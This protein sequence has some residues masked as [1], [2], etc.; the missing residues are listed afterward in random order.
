MNSIKHLII[1]FSLLFS[2]SIASAE[3]PSS[4]HWTL[5]AYNQ[6]IVV[7]KNNNSALLILSNSQFE[8]HRLDLFCNSMENKSSTSIALIINDRSV[9]F[10]TYCS[11]EHRVFTPK[12]EEGLV[13]IFSILMTGDTMKISNLNFTTNKFQHVADQWQQLNKDAI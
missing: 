5:N 4:M 6:P 11:N 10:I 3:M 13:F 12:T 7:A 1:L 9:K 2:I 8:L